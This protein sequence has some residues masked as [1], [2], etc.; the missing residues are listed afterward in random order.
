MGRVRTIIAQSAFE[1][2]S[3]APTWHKL[4]QSQPHSVFQRFAWNHLA[5]EIFSDRLEPYVVCV[6]SDSG[7]AIVPAAINHRQQ[8]V[9]LIGETLFD[10][11]DV[12]HTG[13]P[14]MLRLAWQQVAKTGHPLSVCCIT[15]VISERWA[16]LPLQPFCM[17]PEVRCEMVDEQRFRTAHSR[18][19]RHFRRLQKQGVELR[20]FRGGDSQVVR[21]IYHRKAEQF[22]VDATNVF[23]DP[24]RREFMIAA[25][26]LENESC[27]IFTLQSAEGELVAGI[28]SFRDGDV[29][30]FYTIYFD[31]AWARFSPG[32]VLLY[33]VTA[34]TLAD[35]MG[36]DYM[37][38]E[39]PYKLRFAN[40]SRPLYKLEIEASDLAHAF[41]RRAK[42]A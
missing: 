34:R 15:P 35:G 41:A 13:D 14:E 32:V 21:R 36:C 8:R 24:L 3:I 25:C 18:V 38:G 4:A 30:R 29:R 31:P 7:A 42:V 28:I 1:M 9:E 2:D 11:R 23:R 6:V 22:A 5:A 40:S 12:L 37:T 19:G 26:A 33:E 10:Y 27:D 20:Q 17:A 16:E 39:Y